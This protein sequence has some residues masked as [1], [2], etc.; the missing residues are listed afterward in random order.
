MHYRLKKEPNNPILATTY[1][2]YRNFCNSLLKKS[3]FDYEKQELEMAESNTKKF[4][5]SIKTITNSHKSKKS[6]QEL[7]NIKTTPAT[8]VNVVN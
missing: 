4:W 2:R 5:H 7:L 8:S 3:K 6:N 1:R